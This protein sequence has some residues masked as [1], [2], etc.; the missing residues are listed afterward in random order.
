MG[1]GEALSERTVG[2]RCSEYLNDVTRH[3]TKVYTQKV[4][5]IFSQNKAFKASNIKM[6]DNILL[7]VIENHV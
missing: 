4:I 3:H 6:Q 2:N 7:T 1:E 5:G